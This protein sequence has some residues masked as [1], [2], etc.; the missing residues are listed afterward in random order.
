M[1]IVKKTQRQEFK[2]DDNCVIYEYWM[3]DKAIDGCIVKLKGRYPKNGLAENAVSKEMA[4]VIAGSG[5]VVIED[6][7]FGIDQ[8]D[9]I[10]INPGEKFYWEG[11]IEL[12]IPCTPAWSTEQYK[13]VE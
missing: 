12:F 8:G 5:K 11:D 1:K 13:V 3:D 10:L 4:Y 6:K 7:E 2:H 9:A